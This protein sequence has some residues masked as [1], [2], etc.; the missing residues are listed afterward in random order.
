M[1]ASKGYSGY[2]AFSESCIELGNLI[3]ADGFELI[4]THCRPVGIAA[5]FAR[6]SRLL[7]A[8]CEGG[9]L[10]VDLLVERGESWMRVSLDQAIWISGVRSI[11]DA[12]DCAAQL[13][14]FI[15]LYEHWKNWVASETPELD[16]R[17][18]FLLSPNDHDRYL[19][20]Q[21]GSRSKAR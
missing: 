20:F 5:E 10:Y 16:S 11:V 18:C 7:F 1:A 4:A 2:D 15:A 3:A 14:L 12:G 6:Q 17:F 13:N 21:R 8:V 9:V 19:R